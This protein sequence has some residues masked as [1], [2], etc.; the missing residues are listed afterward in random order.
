MRHEIV[1]RS[2]TLLLHDDEDGVRPSSGVEVWQLGPLGILF[3]LRGGGFYT[4]LAANGLS[5]FRDAEIDTVLTVVS[6]KHHRA[7][8]IGLKGAKVKSL[9]A[10]G[11][12]G[13]QFVLIAI[14]AD[15]ATSPDWFGVCE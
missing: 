9:G 14:R 1:R 4:R 5:M 13:K 7:M 6:A 15:Y 10:F 11:L 8:R 12:V 3:S 2:L